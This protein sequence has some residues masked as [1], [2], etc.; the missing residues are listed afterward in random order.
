VPP[1]RK[2]LDPK[3]DVVFVRL[4]G[5][6]Q[7]Q[8][9]LISLLNEVLRPPEPITAVELQAQQDIPDDVHGKV[10]IF[11]VRVR[12]Q[13]GDCINV[14]MQLRRHPALRERVLFY[15]AKLY[16]GQLRRG[17]GYSD[18][19]R[20]AVILIT[21]FAEGP[22]DD[23]HSVFQLTE[24]KRG[25]P[26]SDHIQVHLLELPKLRGAR[27]GNDEPNL[28]AWCR[29]LSA[30]TDEELEALAM[31]DPILRDAKLALERLTAD[32]QLREQAER[33]EEEIKLY[34][35][36]TKK[37][38][39]EGR[40]EGLAEGRVEGLAEG[41]VEGLAEGR[42]EGLAEGQALTLLRLL[43]LKFGELKP[44]VRAHVFSAT[45]ADLAR[46]TDRVLTA[47]SLDELLAT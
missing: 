26:F 35:F 11:D 25:A 36:G 31:Q 18:L 8:R 30:E 4:F 15:W 2:T 39:E 17:D 16:V 37:L 3:L 43:T 14:E 12:L 33:L 47:T 21:D 46:W 6:E 42:V 28:A 13:N 23:F 19:R 10:V 1:K 5:A 24:R 20:T 40:V 38:R 29:F 32:P 34:Q 22:G 44:D 41:R 27:A 9:F 45:R 7:N